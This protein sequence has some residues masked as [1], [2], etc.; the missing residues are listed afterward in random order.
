MKL[1]TLS[2]KG[3]LGAL[4][5][6]VAQRKAKCTPRACAAHLVGGLDVG[7][8]H[9]ASFCNTASAIS[10]ETSTDNGLKYS[11]LRKTVK[12]SSRRAKTSGKALEKSSRCKTRGSAEAGAAEGR[13]PSSRSSRL[14]AAAASTS[15]GAPTW[16]LRTSRILRSLSG[17][18]SSSSSNCSASIA[19]PTPARSGAVSAGALA[20]S[21]SA[22]YR[23]C[24]TC[25]KEKCFCRGSTKANTRFHMMRRDA[26]E[27]ESNKS[28]A[29]MAEISSGI[30]GVSRP[31]PTSTPPGAIDA[32]ASTAPSKQRP[33]IR[34]LAMRWSK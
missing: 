26:S 21:A 9:S 12:E 31:M 10:G 23:S 22:T 8:Q 25:E 7:P 33:K 27:G 16:E 2:F 4:R 20:A 18:T 11:T 5:W 13:G 24:E 14:V 17:S 6:N 29:C 19:S 3:P 32:R 30:T 1:R 34:M 28:E 15:V